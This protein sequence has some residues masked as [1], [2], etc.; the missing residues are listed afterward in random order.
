MIA[1]VMVKELWHM[2]KEQRVFDRARFIADLESLHNPGR[3]WKNSPE[4]I[5]NPPRSVS[6]LG[7]SFNRVLK[8]TL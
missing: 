5:E 2:Q 8:N 3:R 6:Q 7:S 4:P 1:S